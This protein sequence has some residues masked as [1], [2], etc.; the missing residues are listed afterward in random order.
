MYKTM[1]GVSLGSETGENPCIMDSV[2]IGRLLSVEAGER[3]R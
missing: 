2:S 1:S 3:S